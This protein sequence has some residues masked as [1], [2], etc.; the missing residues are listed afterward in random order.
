MYYIICE[1]YA[2]CIQEKELYYGAPA[3]R[4]LSLDSYFLTEVE[5]LERNPD[6]GRR[7]KKKV[8]EY[9]YEPEMEQAYRY[10]GMDI[11]NTQ[12]VISYKYN[13]FAHKSYHIY[14]YVL[15]T[16]YNMYSFS[17]MEV[18]LLCILFTAHPTAAIELVYSIYCPPH[19]C[20][21]AS[22]FYLLPTPLLL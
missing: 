22:I 15:C 10:G 8:Q 9:E 18:P 3:P 16:Y 17:T 20:Y 14:M 1:Q 12:L 4:L 19:W 11:P 21:R 13:N 7:V 2:Y 5:R 6:T